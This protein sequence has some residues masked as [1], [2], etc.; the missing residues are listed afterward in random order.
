MKP[1]AL[2]AKDCFDVY[3]VA[4]HA[5]LVYTVGGDGNIMSYELTGDFVDTPTGKCI[6][7]AAKAVVFPKSKKK[8]FGFSYPLNVQ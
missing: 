8:K 3:G 4:G 2:A 5:K 1:V 7:K 6:D